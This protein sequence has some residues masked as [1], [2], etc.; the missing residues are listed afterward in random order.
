MKPAGLFLLVPAG[1]VVLAPVEGSESGLV[2]REIKAHIREGLAPYQPSPPKANGEV[3]A[4]SPATDPNVLV[5]PTMIVKEVRLPPDAAD[6]LMSA[7]D[8]NRKME[9]L[10]LDEVAKDGPLNVMLNSVA[11]PILNQVSIAL[12]PRFSRIKDSRAI[13]RS[14]E[15]ER[16]RA[17]Y[18]AKEI[19]RLA[20]VTE[21]GKS[22]DPSADKK[23]QQEIDN[24]HATRP[25]GGR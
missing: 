11:L 21:V 6:H 12:P 1:L 20:H 19:E 7:R 17:L 18:R 15:I 8:F 16:G 2:S 5:L 4:P 24:T 10:Y 13:Y 22:A 23:F 3:L 25:A 9:N 14:V